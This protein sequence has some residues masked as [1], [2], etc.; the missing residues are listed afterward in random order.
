MEKWTRTNN[1]IN[2]IKH[3]NIMKKEKYS[4]PH[5]VVV[6]LRMENCLLQTSNTGNGK[7]PQNPNSNEFDF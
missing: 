2:Y 3:N 6:E 7:I 5:M 1:E 4:P